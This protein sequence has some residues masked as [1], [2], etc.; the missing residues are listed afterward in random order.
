MNTTD[1]KENPMKQIPWEKIEDEY[2]PNADDD[3]RLR[4]VKEKIFS[5]PEPKRK[6]LLLWID[7][8]SFSEVARR[9]NCSS[10]TVSKYIN[11]IREEIGI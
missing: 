10:P 7:S 1:S 2:R 8:Q 6:V 4:E 5:L 11:K 3:D 9:M